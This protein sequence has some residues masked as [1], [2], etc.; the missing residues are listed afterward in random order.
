MAFPAGKLESFCLL[1]APNGENAE[2][3]D[4]EE[5]AAFSSSV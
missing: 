5:M 2:V 1:F 3:A 4:K